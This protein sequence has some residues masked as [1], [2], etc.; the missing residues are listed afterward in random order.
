MTGFTASVRA[1]LQLLNFSD[2]QMLD[3]MVEA[4]LAASREVMRFYGNQAAEATMKSDGSP[5]TQADVNAERVIL[6]ILRAAYP[7][8]PIVAEEEAA[9]ASTPLASNRFFLVD[10]LDGTKEFIHRSGDFT[11][12]IALIE[13]GV[14]VMG[15][16]CAPADGQ[17]Y[18]AAGSAAFRGSIVNGR[19]TGVERIGVRA[20]PEH[21]VAVGSRSHSTDATIDW[22]RRFSVADFVSRGSSLKFCLLASGAADI[23]P[24]LGRTMEWD[25]AAGDAILRAAGGIVT[26]LEGRA[27]VYN[28]RGQATDADFTNGH[29]VAY[30]DPALLSRQPTNPGI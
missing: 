5:V 15:V 26:D 22:L 12:N 20:A 28:K 19:L 9:A 24:R 8:L 25:T 11:V 2:S 16:V 10:P 29:F 3:V 4:S 30:G 27:L 6:Q 17:L 13:H 21:L 14:P 7:E 1:N 18:A 23:Y